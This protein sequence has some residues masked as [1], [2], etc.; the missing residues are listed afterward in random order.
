MK[1]DVGIT[2]EG[3]VQE[4]IMAGVRYHK[5]LDPKKNYIK[6]EL[7]KNKGARGIAPP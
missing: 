5:P 2:Q 1:T 6:K 4:F 3:R 7:A